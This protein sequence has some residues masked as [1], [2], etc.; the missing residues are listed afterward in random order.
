MTGTTLFPLNRLVE[1][2]P[3]VAAIH[4]NK[5]D[6]R[7]NRH[8]LLKR[9]IPLL[10]CLWND[11]LHF[12]AVHPKVTNDNVIAAG[13][14]PKIIKK[15]KYFAIPIEMLDPQLIAVLDW[16]KFTMEKDASRYSHFDATKM[17]YY[18]T[19]PQATLDFY[20][21]RTSNGKFFGTYHFVPHILYKGS[22]DVTGLEIIEV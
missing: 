4:F 9:K 6:A 15:K 2:M 22:V 12:T 1:L 3:D 19:V 17:D 18:A 7:E 13:V 14:D 10:D 8:V 21:E 5:Y 11:V 20:K 16:Q